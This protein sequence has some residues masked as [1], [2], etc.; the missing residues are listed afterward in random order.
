MREARLLRLQKALHR[1]RE[2]DEGLSPVRLRASP[3]ADR[4]QGLRFLHVARATRRRG[5]LDLLRLAHTI[6]TEGR[7]LIEDED[8]EAGPPIPTFKRYEPGLENY[9]RIMAVEGVEHRWVPTNASYAAKLYAR[10]H[11]ATATCFE[12][13]GSQFATTEDRYRESGPE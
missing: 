6:G 7:A 4:D 1:Q 12:I 5:R 9:R 8:V 13:D 3:R 11:S 10:W 2:R